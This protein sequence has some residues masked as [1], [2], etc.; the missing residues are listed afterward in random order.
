MENVNSNQT[1]EQDESQALDQRRRLLCL[2]ESHQNPETD[3]PIELR[4]IDPGA[5][6]HDDQAGLEWFRYIDKS[7]R[8]SH[9]SET[10]GGSS[11][12]YCLE[13]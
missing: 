13:W 8:K 6:D 11:F 7:T 1:A 5:E 4:W 3:S 9:S 12:S 10:D 2:W